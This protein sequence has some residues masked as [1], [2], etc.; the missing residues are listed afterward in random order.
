[1]IS[2]VFSFALTAIICSLLSPGNEKEH[3]CLEDLLYALLRSL[4]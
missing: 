3:K 1:L 4:N 2:L